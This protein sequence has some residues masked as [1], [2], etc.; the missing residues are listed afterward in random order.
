MGCHQAR[1]LRFVGPAAVLACVAPMAFGQNLLMHF[2]MDEAES[3]LV[4]VQSG[5]IAN[6]VDSGHLY[7]R[8]G[9]PGLGTSVA[10]NANGSWQF[11]LTDS[12]VFNVLLNDFS[13]TSWVYLDS[14]TVAGKTGPISSLHQ[15]IGDDVAWDADGWSFGVWSDGRVRFTKNGIVDL[16]T[17][18]SHVVQ[19]SW[20]HLAATVSSNDG[21]TIYVDG[22]AVQTFGNT[23]SVNPWPGNNGQDDVY[24]IGRSN[25]NGEARWF[26]GRIDDVR[27]YDGVLSADQ[28]AALIV[29]EPSTF[30]LAALGL[31][32]LGF[33]AWRR[34]R[35]AQHPT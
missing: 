24:G 2:T 14:M 21:I 23:A 29:P 15:I 7:L 27:F 22:V 32:S 11:S 31:L 30:A 9:P 34:R 33:V 25:G 16:D 18:A 28:V 17:S 3:P 6:A 8:P 13:V 35:F 1:I 12:T 19:D 5:L 10:L 20:A 4:D 26:A